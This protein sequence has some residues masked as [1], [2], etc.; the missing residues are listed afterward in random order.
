MINEYI[1]REDVIKVIELCQRKG[2]PADRLDIIR[3]PCAD[4]QPI[5]RGRWIGRG[6]VW[7]EDWKCS[8]CNERLGKAEHSNYCPN[9]GARM[10]GDKYE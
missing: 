5:K 2:E 6:N 3:I 7:S 4:V 9:C 8:Y 10:D 1:S